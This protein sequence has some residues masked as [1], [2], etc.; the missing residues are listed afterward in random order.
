LASAA[1]V[2]DGV[3]GWI[4]RRW[5]T[6]SAFGARFDMEVDALLI[7]VLA[8]LAW[9]HSKAGGW[10]MLSGLLRYL[11]VG[12]GWIWAWMR[13]PLTPTF[14]GRTICVVQVVGLIVT[15]TPL[16]KPSMSV[17]IAAASLAALAVSFLID[18]VHLWRQRHDSAIAVH[19][20]RP[21]AILTIAVAVL[22]ASVTFDNIWPTPFAWWNGKV[23]IELAGLLLVLAG[24]AAVR[25]GPRSRI[26]IGLLSVC[27]MPLV[28]GRYVEGT[29]PA[30]YGRDVN[31]YWDLRFI[32]DVAAMVIRVAPIWLMALSL[33]AVVAVLALLY[34]LF[35]WAFGRIDAAMTHPRARRAIAVGACAA[36]V[37]FGLERLRAAYPEDRYAPTPVTQTYAH[38]VA[39]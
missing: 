12:A 8:I 28:L 3:D 13:R 11:F 15:I 24:I 31:L 38:Q 35:V 5:R 20:W 14:R 1:A 37:I 26:A 16:V 22:D 4:A 36:F 18:I 7:L 30:L 23:S 21:W 2:L 27:W 33:V 32:P 39:L 19:P 34:R 29:A 9:Q 6:A 17:W 10:V 25:S